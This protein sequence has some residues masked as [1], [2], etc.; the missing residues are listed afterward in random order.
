M[1]DV[2]LAVFLDVDVSRRVELERSGRLPG[3]RRG[4]GEQVVPIEARR[5]G[6]P[7]YDVV[8]LAVGEHKNRIVWLSVALDLS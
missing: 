5:I 3:Q 7:G 8:G 1:E 4:V 6:A 2:R